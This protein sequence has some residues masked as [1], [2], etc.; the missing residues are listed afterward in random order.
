MQKAFLF[1]MCLCFFLF[2]N[3]VNANTENNILGIEMYKFSK[4]KIAK[5]VTII[6]VLPNTNAWNAGIRIADRILKVNDVDATKMTPEEIKNFIS[7]DSANIV[8]LTLKTKNG[9]KDFIIKKENINKNKVMSYPQWKNFCT[10]EKT[11]NEACYI[12]TNDE[13]KKLIEIGYGPFYVSSIGT[14][15]AQERY[16]YENNLDICNKSKDPSMCY[17]Q[18]QQNIQMQKMNSG[19]NKINST[20]MIYR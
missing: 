6:N 3:K 14:K 4:P 16:M 13:V 15:L 19:I 8:K 10:N 1:I 7:S 5:E 20:L 9:T 17:I 2:L 18:L 11:E 12:H